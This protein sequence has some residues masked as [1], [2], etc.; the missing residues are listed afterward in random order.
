MKANR[1]STTVTNRRRFLR[2]A[3]GTAAATALLA[4]PTLAVG[5]DMAPVAWLS[6]TR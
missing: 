1:D 2:L 5:A 4:A 6:P 3:A